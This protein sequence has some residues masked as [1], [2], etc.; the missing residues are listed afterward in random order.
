MFR[1]MCVEDKNH[2]P[3]T[4]KVLQVEKKPLRKCKE[5]NLRPAPSRVPTESVF[6][7]GLSPYLLTVSRSQALPC[8]S[9]HPT[10]LSLGQFLSGQFLDSAAV[11]DLDSVHGPACLCQP[12]T[13]EIVP[14]LDCV[15]QPRTSLPVV[16][17]PHVTVA[18]VSNL[19]S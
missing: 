12:L 8:N 10:P 1:E 15:A 2:S 3:T 18:E 6:S 13:T 17:N 5:V 11:A 9:S 7:N 16:D 14:L 19:T 4:T